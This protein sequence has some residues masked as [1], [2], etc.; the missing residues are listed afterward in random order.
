MRPLHIATL[1]TVRARRFEGISFRFRRRF[2]S[3]RLGKEKEEG[4]ARRKGL[5]ASQI[6]VSSAV[7]ILP[8]IEL[9]TAAWAAQ[10]MQY[11]EKGLCRNLV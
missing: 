5:P 7:F 3:T 11:A 1:C 6:F 8:M 4:T 9:G 2:H 10:Y